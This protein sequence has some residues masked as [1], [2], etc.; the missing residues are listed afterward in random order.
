MIGF[1]GISILYT[2]VMAGQLPDIIMQYIGISTNSLTMGRSYFMRTILNDFKSVGFMS[3]TVRYRSMEMDI[4]M[5]YVEMG[6]LSVIATVY[7]ITK[8]VKD[9]WYELFMVSFCLFEVLTSQWLGVPYFWILMYIT[10]GCIVYKDEG[11]KF[12]GKRKIK[13]TGFGLKKVYVRRGRA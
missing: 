10:L 8:L 4:P 9:N 2:K 1:I 5:I 7:F 11:E 6:I 12:L 3:S 13:F